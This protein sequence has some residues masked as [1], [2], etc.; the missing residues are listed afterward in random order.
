M[1]NILVVW[2]YTISFILIMNLCDT[3]IELLKNEIKEYVIAYKEN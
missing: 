1:I 3:E 2:I